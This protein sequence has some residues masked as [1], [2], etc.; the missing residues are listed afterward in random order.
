ML[1]TTG[2]ASV[3]LAAVVVGGSADVASAAL[4]KK[5]GLSGL[6]GTLSSNAT[7][8]QQQLICDPADGT[9]SGAIDPNASALAQGAPRRGS[10]SVSYD[11][12]IVSLS[13]VQLGSGYAGSGRVEVQ[14]AGGRRVLQD[15]A[16][17]LSKPAGTE[18][19][20][21]QLL[22]HHGPRGTLPPDNLFGPKGEPGKTPVAGG[23]TTNM[24]DGPE[25]FDT[26]SFFFTYKAGV[27]DTTV[28]AYDIF[29]N[30]GG[31]ASGG[32]ADFLTGLD[33]T[34]GQ[35][36]TVPASQIAPAHVQG[37][38]ITVPLPPAV[39]A[40]SATLA[41]VGLLGW[42]RRRRTTAR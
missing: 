11:P 39:C 9:E 19:G 3:M 33:V 29:A 17:F 16:A 18:T 37:A 12:S 4:A 38:L 1:K 26:H 14:V 5:R 23:F 42:A 21:V 27:A 15:L 10:D 34:T 35:E 28:A 30:P 40:G 31:R 8:R 22:F 25:G 32:S 20:Y 13:A 2:L 7:I 24:S 41:A 6:S 36:F